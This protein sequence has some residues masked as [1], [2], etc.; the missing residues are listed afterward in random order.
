M[1]P[2]ETLRAMLGHTTLDMSL[3]YAR[4]AGVDLAAAHELAD[5]A[6]S[7]KTRV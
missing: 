3:H 1:C 4:I 7:L 2:L 5:P 6:R